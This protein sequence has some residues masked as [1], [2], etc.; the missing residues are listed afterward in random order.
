MRVIGKTRN[1]YMIQFERMEDRWFM[2]Y[3]GPWAIQNKLFVMDDWQP[4]MILSNLE[5]TSLP[6]W[7]QIWG[8]P[9]EYMSSNAA[10]LLGSMVGDVIQT[11]AV[12]QENQNL[13]FLRV[14]V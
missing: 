13:N 14:R 10:E 11:K 8:L 7:V 12:D 3:Q 4:N 6:I 1:I 9:L 2:Q 5:F